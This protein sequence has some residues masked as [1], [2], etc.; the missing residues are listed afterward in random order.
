MFAFLKNIGK[1][2]QETS[3]VEEKG[4]VKVNGAGKKGIIFNT[5]L[6]VV[7]HFLNHV[8]IQNYPMFKKHRKL[9]AYT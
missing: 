3:K 8:N 4:R 5:H 9:W 6:F 2:T 7:F 1:I